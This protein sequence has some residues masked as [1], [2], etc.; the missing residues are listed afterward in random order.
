LQSDRHL[1]FEGAGRAEAMGLSGKA[2]GRCRTRT[3][4]NRRAVQSNI[5]LLSMSGWLEPSSAPSARRSQRERRRLT[6]MY[7]ISLASLFRKEGPTISQAFVAINL[8][9]YNLKW[10]NAQSSKG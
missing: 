2:K 9:F 4:G 10:L 7:A 8:S 1:A 6:S 3:C 5:S